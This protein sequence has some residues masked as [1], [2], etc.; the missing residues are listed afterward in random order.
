MICTYPKFLWAHML[1]RPHLCTAHVSMAQMIAPRSTV[2]KSF[3][4]PPTVLPLT[5]GGG[6][7][8]PESLIMYA[9]IWTAQ[10]SA[11]RSTVCIGFRTPP[12]ILPLMEGGGGGGLEC[13]LK[14]MHRSAVKRKARRSMAQGIFRTPPTD[15][16]LTVGGG[17][18][19]GPE[20]NLTLAG[21]LSIRGM[22]LLV[23]N[24]TASYCLTYLVTS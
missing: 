8:G 2:D 18:G 15:L 1:L 3:R 6:G 7:G 14:S 19:G 16:P 17:G 21:P 10:V 11:L 24:P 20:W 4:T 5:V 12:S 9:R 22:N 23:P 13:V